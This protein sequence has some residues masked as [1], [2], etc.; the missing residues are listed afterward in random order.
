MGKSNEKFQPISRNYLNKKNEKQCR[1]KTFQNTKEINSETCLPPVN[2][3]V[4]KLN[5]IWLLTKIEN[6]KK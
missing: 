3:T 6:F 5:E 1:H 2:G 4:S